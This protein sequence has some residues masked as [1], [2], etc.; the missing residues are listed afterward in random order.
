MAEIRYR[1]KV[2]AIRGKVF[3]HVDGL[4][5]IEVE[6]TRLSRMSKSESAM[7]EILIREFR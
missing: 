6:C 4:R 2:V 3:A 5:A 7:A 1:L